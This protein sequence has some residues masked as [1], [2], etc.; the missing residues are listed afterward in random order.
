MPT[1]AEIIRIIEPPMEPRKWCGA[2]FIDIKRRKRENQ[3]ITNA[4]NKYCDDFIT[5]RITAPEEDRDL[6]EDAIHKSEQQS[7]EYWKE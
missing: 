2:T 5:A 7:I 4:E 1:P 3:F 6:I